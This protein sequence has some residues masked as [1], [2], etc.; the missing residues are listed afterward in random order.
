LGF[1]WE[2]NY[3]S[4]NSTWRHLFDTVRLCNCIQQPLCRQADQPVTVTEFSPISSADIGKH[5]L[6]ALIFGTRKT[7]ILR[8]GTLYFC[9]DSCFYIFLITAWGGI[10]LYLHPRHRYY[11]QAG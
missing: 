1:Y 2:I 11:G 3:I 8:Q 6:D 4:N 7:K 9:S 10:S 5:G